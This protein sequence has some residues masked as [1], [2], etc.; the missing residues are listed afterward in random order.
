MP[1]VPV[2][3][4]PISRY[5]TVDEVAAWNALA[6]QNTR[7]CNLFDQCGISLPIHHLGAALPVGLQL[8][9]SSGH[10]VALLQA[11]MAVENALH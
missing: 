2:L 6:S 10:D 4:Q 1:T 3:P 8:C 7:P 9:A 5:T 11:A